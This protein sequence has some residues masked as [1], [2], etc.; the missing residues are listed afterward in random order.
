MNKKYIH[1]ANNETLAYLEKGSGSKT[2]ILIH[3][4]FS[5][6]MYYLPLFNRLPEDIHT[7]AMDLRGYGDSTYFQRVLSL[8][9]FAKDIKLFMDALHIEKAFIVGWS[10]GGGVA[11]ELAA[12]YPERVEKLV[13]INSSTHKGY[14]V[15]KKDESGKAIVGAAYVNADEMALDPIQVKPLAEA[16]SG[17]N[18]AF[19]KYIFDITIYTVNKPTEE[20]TFLY[21]NESL[22]Q[23]NLADADFALASQ[24]MSDVANFYKDGEKTIHNVTMPVLHIW[25]TKDITVPE[26]MILENIKALETVS[27]YVRFEECGHS[28]LVDKPDDL[29]KEILKFIEK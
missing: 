17:K 29:T 4:N 24:N 6:S 25:G 5:S 1:L 22:K 23:R 21:I 19:V 27:T 9:D 10:L 8:K 16:Q 7:Y 15:F 11:M 2:L 3:G 20:E 28:P 12:H 13:L 18:F 26:Y 14:P